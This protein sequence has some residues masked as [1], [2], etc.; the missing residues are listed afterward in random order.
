[1]STDMPQYDITAEAMSTKN[2]RVNEINQ[3]WGP[4]RRACL[5]RGVSDGRSA[6]SKPRRVYHVIDTVTP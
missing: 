4:G 5:T 6:G 1:M 3:V 2:S